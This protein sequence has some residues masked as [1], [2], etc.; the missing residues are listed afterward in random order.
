MS[1]KASLK[2]LLKS[3]QDIVKD[4]KKF[5]KD[6][7][8]FV[9]G[10]FRIKDKKN[11]SVKQLYSKSDDLYEKVK[12]TCTQNE[13]VLCGLTCYIYTVHLTI[14]KRVIFTWRR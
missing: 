3:Y 1:D 11:A 8:P 7:V 4:P 13:F 12:P 2:N 6:F 14:W 5:K 10:L 9:V